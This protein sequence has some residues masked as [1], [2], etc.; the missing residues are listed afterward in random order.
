MKKHVPTPVTIV[1][2]LLLV[3]ALFVLLGSILPGSHEAYSLF[4]FLGSVVMIVACIFIL[5]ASACAVPFALI[6]ACLLTIDVLHVYISTHLMG[7][8]LRETWHLFRLL[9]NIVLYWA[10]FLWYRH[11]KNG[12]GDAGG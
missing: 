10:A 3:D 6:V 11:W 5:V 12:R 1:C 9:L 8:S 7:L 2:L 4:Y